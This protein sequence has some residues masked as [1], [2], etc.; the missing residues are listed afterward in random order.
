LGG[1]AG[2]WVATVV[3]MTMV[4][5]VLMSMRTIFIFLILLE[6]IFLRL[7]WDFTIILS[8]RQQGERA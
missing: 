1:F 2:A 6:V 4:V 3:A 8:V 5:I 7:L